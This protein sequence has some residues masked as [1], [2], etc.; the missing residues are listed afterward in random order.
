MDDCLIIGGGVIGLSLALELAAGGWRVRVVDRGRPGHEASWAAA[1]LIPPPPNPPNPT[2][3]EQLTALSCRL[4]PALSAMLRT[5]TGIDNGYLNCGGINL[6]DK[7][8]APT[9]MTTAAELRR[10]RAQVEELSPAAVA[11]LE[12]AFRPALAAGK[13]DSAIRLPEET[14]FRNPRHMQALE[15]ACKKRGVEIS[16][17]TEVKDFDVSGG[18]I[19]GALTKN[20][21]LAA[22]RYCITSGT[23]SGRLLQR[24]GRQATI[25]PIR[26][27]IVLLKSKEPLLRRVVYVGPHYFVPR[28]DGRTLVGTTVEDVG[29]DCRATPEGVRELLDFALEWLPQL[30]EAEVERSWAGLRPGSGDGAPYLGSIPGMSNAFIAAGHFRSGL[31]L[32]PATALVMAQLM[33]GEKL[34]VDLESFRVDRE[35]L[36][37]R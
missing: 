23:W 20:G 13:I 24:L 28:D 33:R 32:A 31:I 9:L 3:L 36:G 7:K 5:E 34:A 27:Q 21:P 6:A 17:D 25:K 16:P 1:G 8:L 26:G 22:K 37:V 15:A 18:E 14:Q 10:V 19:R 35:A 4:Y 11:E 30:R 2:P 12:P 29:F